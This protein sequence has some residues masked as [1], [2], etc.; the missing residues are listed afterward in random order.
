MSGYDGRRSTSLVS[1][2]TAVQIASYMTSFSI[3]LAA[4][5]LRIIFRKVSIPT[6][7]AEILIAYFNEAGGTLT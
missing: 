1:L 6:W 2:T 3:S 7:L 5:V 4:T